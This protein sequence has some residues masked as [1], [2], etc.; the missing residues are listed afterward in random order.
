MRLNQE[1][2]ATHFFGTLFLLFSIYTTWLILAQNHTLSDQVAE[3]KD[4][5][6]SLELKVKVLEYRKSADDIGNLAL[7]PSTY[8]SIR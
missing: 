8:Q 3:Q 4:H 1:T 5:I 6:Q 7:H 2:G